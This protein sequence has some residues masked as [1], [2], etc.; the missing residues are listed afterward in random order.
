[1]I[2]KRFGNWT[3]F[4][5][6]AGLEEAG[7]HETAISNEQL[8]DLVKERTVQ[9]GRSPSVKEFRYGTLVIGRFGSWSAFLLEAGLEPAKR[10]PLKAQLN[11]EELIAAI[12]Q[13]AVE[14]EK[15]PEVKDFERASLASYRFGT[16]N[17]F[18]KKAG[19]I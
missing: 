19:L 10:E 18:L 12:K 17:T 11:D 15:I 13:R 2:L 8:L 6:S 4:L 5:N 14:L 3:T 1:M 7:K 9:I 16:W